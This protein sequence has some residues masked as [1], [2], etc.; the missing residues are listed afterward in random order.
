MKTSNISPKKFIALYWLSLLLYIFSIAVDYPR[1]QSIAVVC[2]IPF[3][4]LT[5]NSKKRAVNGY[6]YILFMAW[7]GDVLLLSENASTTFSLIISYWGNLLAIS[8]LL[9]RRLVGMMLTQIQKKRDL[10]IVGYG[11]HYPEYYFNNK[12]LRRNNYNSSIILWG[13]LDP[14]RSSKFCHLL[15]KQNTPKSEFNIRIYFHMLKCGYKSYRNN[16]F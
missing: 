3:L 13:Y 8:A 5:T 1:I 14:Y 11:Y 2:M 6:F 9:Q 7:I 12:T 15:Q 16:L 10:C 4:A